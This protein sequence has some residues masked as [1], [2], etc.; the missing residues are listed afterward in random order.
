MM[1]GLA[2]SAVS[3]PSL[4][5]FLDTT[6]SLYFQEEI[7]LRFAYEGDSKSGDWPDL[8]DSTNE[9]RSALGFPPITPINIRTGDLENWLTTSY[10]V[11]VGPMSASMDLPGPAPDAILAKKLETAQRGESAGDNPFPNAGSTPP[12]PVLAVDET[13][14]AELVVLLQGHI[15]AYIL[16]AI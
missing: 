5:R 9:I 11:T 4:Y 14:L 3:G 16:G 13:D 6:A 15:V 12:R 2:Y 10:D 7:G 1:L 8:A